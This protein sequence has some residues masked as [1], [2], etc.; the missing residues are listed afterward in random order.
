[1][2]KLYSAREVVKA[3]I[4]AGFSEVKQK[5]SHLKMRGVWNGKL[6]TVIIPMH[7]TLAHGTFQSIISQSGM[8][9]S[10]FEEY[11]R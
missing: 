9:K 6:Q 5:G 1:M 3:L 4:R 2:P 7:K 10:E 11:L 8:T